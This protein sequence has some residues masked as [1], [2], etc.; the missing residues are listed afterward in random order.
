MRTTNYLLIATILVLTGCASTLT[1][2][3]DS[4]GRISKLIGKGSQES[5]IEQGD[6]KVSL[7]TKQEPFKDIVSLNALKE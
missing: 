7:N 2:E 5:S 4:E 3:R 1:I 6:E